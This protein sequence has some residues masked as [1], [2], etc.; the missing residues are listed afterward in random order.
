MH[1]SMQHD[2]ENQTLHLLVGHLGWVARDCAVIIV[3]L[4]T[5]ASHCVQVGST[6]R[7]AL[8][9]RAQPPH[10]SQW[11]TAAPGMSQCRLSRRWTAR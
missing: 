11:Q 1:R 7:S 9:A 2:S 5:Y 6:P 10:I 4:Q 8:H 3:H